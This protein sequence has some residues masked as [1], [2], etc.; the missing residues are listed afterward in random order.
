MEKVKTKLLG[1][2]VA[3]LAVMAILPAVAFAETNVTVHWDGHY[4]STNGTYVYNKSAVVELTGISESVSGQN[5]IGYNYAK[6]TDP[7]SWQVAAVET[8][9]PLERVFSSAVCAGESASTAW[10][11]GAYMII[12]TNDMPFVSSTN[13]AYNKYLGSKEAWTK[14]NLFDLGSLNFY[15]TV[16]HSTD[17]DD[18]SVWGDSLSRALAK[19]ILALDWAT[20]T[21]STTSGNADALRQTLAP[22][23]IKTPRLFYGLPEV[24]STMTANVYGQRFPYTVTDI[25]LYKD[26]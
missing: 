7:L 24:S 1:I 19:P 22:T 4:D 11:N 17:L 12:A 6:K 13:T 8:Y 5:Y 16:I 21:L 14:Q 15:K 9:V 3:A 10:N 23:A 26:N 18:S 2:I 20:G 25:Y